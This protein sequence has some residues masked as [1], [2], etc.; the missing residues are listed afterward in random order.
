MSKNDMIIIVNYGLKNLNDRVLPLQAII[1][2]L[3]YN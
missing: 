3:K 2:Y 1:D